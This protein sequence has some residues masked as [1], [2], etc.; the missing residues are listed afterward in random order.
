MAEAAFMKTQQLLPFLL[1][2]FGSLFIA[3]QVG[4]IVFCHYQ[5]ENKIALRELKR[6]FIAIFFLLICRIRCIIVNVMKQI[7][8][9][10]INDH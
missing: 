9:E 5:K 1:S 2:S 8:K 10:N 3:A 7:R 4:L 6:F